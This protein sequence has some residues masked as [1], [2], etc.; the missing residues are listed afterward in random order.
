MAIGSGSIGEFSV[1]ELSSSGGI[2]IGV[3]GAGVIA[4][5]GATP[6]VLTGSLIEVPVATIQ[7]AKN[8]PE[9][10][11]GALQSVPA[12]NVNVV[13]N[14]P[15]ILQ[16]SNNLVPAGNIVVQGQVPDLGGGVIIDSPSRQDSFISSG[17]SIGNHSIA[18]FSI[19]EG[20]P[21]TTLS[22][23]RTARL[24]VRAGGSPIIFTGSMIDVP[25]GAMSL[26]GALPEIQSRRK[27][28]RTQVICS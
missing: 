23:R 24:G 18:E 14:I 10:F 22:G 21:E 17:E 8:A 1:S 16:S 28:L 20:P 25:A 7:V 4:T 27:R 26:V 15:Q 19:G 9:I 11:A 5:S 12:G 2:D 6:D 13:G 3:S